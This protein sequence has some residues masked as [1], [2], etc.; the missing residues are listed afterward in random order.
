MT[1]ASVTKKKTTSFDNSSVFVHYFDPSKA[2]NTKIDLKQLEE[3]FYSTSSRFLFDFQCLYAFFFSF[4]FF[5][6]VKH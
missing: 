6:F 2:K 3:I 1:V 5:L 4:S